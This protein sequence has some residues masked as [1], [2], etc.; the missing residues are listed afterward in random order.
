MNEL[1]IF[2]N[3][4]FGSIRTLEV[5]GEP[6][7]VGK[8]VCT[9]FGDKNH[10][11]SIGRID[12]EDK[13]TVEI[14]DSLGRKQNI[15]AINESGL[16]SL[17][18]AMQPQKANK[19]EVSNAYPTQV[20]ERIDKL[21]RFKRWVTS[22]V[23]PTIRKTGGYVANDDNF[24]DTYLPNADES[25]KLMFKAN[26]QAIR[27]LNNKVGLLETENAQ[28]K[29]IIGEL[30]PSADYTDKIL[31]SK[32]LVTITQIA[33]DYGMSG[34][35]MNS[36]LHDLGVQ[37]KQSGQWMLYSKHH[38][39]GYTHSRT[40]N[41]L[42][43]DGTSDSRMETKWTQKGRLFIYNL[44]KSHNILPLIERDVSA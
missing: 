26:L 19:D 35:K 43:S 29:Q 16:Y 10:N 12:I 15:I 7:F 11:R 17:L 37:Y 25:T 38:E 9:M 22:E 23:L 21:H 44:L 31:N 42:H 30:K 8:D 13:I 36:L 39:K 41:I 6:Y 33:K 28:Q 24:I 32:G 34:Q 18:F 3:S 2:E 1:I 14:L 4:E 27:N 40:I 5:E 20:Q